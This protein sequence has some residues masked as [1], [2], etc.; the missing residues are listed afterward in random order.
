[1]DIALAPLHENEFNKGKSCLK[2]YEYAAI[3]SATLA[4]DVMPYN[5]EVGYC[6]KNTQKD[7]KDKIEKL[8]VDKDFR[9]K[10]AKKQHDWVFENRE[11][12]KTAMLWEKAFLK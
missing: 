10:L 7:W 4:S 8:I 5:K 3:G 6:A 1:M 9:E 12:G 11:L 2:F